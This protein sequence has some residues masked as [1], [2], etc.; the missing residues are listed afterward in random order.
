MRPI[1]ADYLESKVHRVGNE[2]GRV[3]WFDIEDAPT[4]DVQPV[5][6][7]HWVAC[8]DEYEYVLD[9]Y[10]CS[11]CGG[12]QFFAIEPQENGWKYCPNCGAKMDEEGKDD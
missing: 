9:E 10:K 2:S 6:H 1:N 8:E 11:A 4:L 3:Y 5:V 7:A 12:I